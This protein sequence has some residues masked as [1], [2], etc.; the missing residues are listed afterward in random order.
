MMQEDVR[1]LFVKIDNVMKENGGDLAELAVWLVANYKP[2]T[3]ASEPSPLEEGEE[4]KKETSTDISEEVVQK[5]VTYSDEDIVHSATAPEPKVKKP[6][7]IKTAKEQQILNPERTNLFAKRAGVDKIKYETL[8]KDIQ[9]S[10]SHQSMAEEDSD[11]D[12]EGDMTDFD[13]SPLSRHEIQTVASLF[14]TPD[15]G[16]MDI[17]ELQKIQ[18]LEQLAV[19]GSVGKIRRST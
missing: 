14:D 7:P 19:T 3:E 17:S 10:G 1:D 12:T 6:A 11:F 5:I 18:K 9:G 13:G 4:D 15:S 8:V 2:T 16:R